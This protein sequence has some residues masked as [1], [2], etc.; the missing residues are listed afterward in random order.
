MRLKEP[1]TVPTGQQVTE[2]YLHQALVS[3]IC[4]ILLCMACLVGTTWAWFTVT[5]KTDETIWIADPTESTTDSVPDSPTEAT[6]APATEETAGN[7]TQPTDPAETTEAVT[8]PQDPSAPP[9]TE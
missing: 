1:F 5:I 6:T 7:T 8:T 9:E 2:K 3:S 4:S